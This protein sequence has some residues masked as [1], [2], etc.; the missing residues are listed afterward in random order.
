MIRSLPLPL[1]LGDHTMKTNINYVDACHFETIIKDS[2]LD[3]EPQ[4]G[5]IKVKGKTGRQV[6]VASTKRV[7]R[8]DV[9]GF[10]MEGPGFIEPH[11]GPFGAVKQQ[12]DHS[13]PQEEILANFTRLL[14]VLKD[15]APAEKVKRSMAPKKDEPKGWSPET[16]AKRED[17]MALIRK[18]AAEKN[19]TVSE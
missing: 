10:T 11:C 15:L 17:R 7:G 4:K 13:L 1:G 5:F 2:G 6:Y 12:L 14:A 8:V 19:V 16:S 9:S 3:Y 18:V